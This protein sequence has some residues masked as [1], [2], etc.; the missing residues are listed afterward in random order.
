MKQLNEKTI[1]N[2]ITKFGIPLDQHIDR[3][4]NTE[5]GN[6][7]EY[8][9]LK[10]CEFIRSVELHNTNNK[11]IGLV[12]DYIEMDDYYT[13]Y[14]D[15]FD[16]NSVAKVLSCADNRIPSY[17]SYVI[18]NGLSRKDRE[19]TSQN[20]RAYRWL[21]TNAVFENYSMFILE[22][23]NAQLKNDNDNIVWEGF[24]NWIRSKNI[25]LANGQ[26]AFKFFDDTPNPL[27]V[28]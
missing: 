14:V 11:A 17:W 3:L 24:P 10:A 6:D 5:R 16:Y 4:F 19:K 27:V 26:R 13:D 28:V 25:K 15:D 18:G 22:Q 9:Y 20:E 7:A 23:F 2:N 1:I 12:N 8:C 21:M